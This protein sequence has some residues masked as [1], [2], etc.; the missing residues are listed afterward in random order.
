MQ[1]KLL[2][3]RQD[4]KI[5]NVDLRA[6]FPFGGQSIVLLEANNRTSDTLTFWQLDPG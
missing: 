5:G 6:N 2:Q 1:G 4:G 3:L